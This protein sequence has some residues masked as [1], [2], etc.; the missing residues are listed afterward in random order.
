[1]NP[2]KILIVDDDPDFAEGVAISLEIAGHGVEIAASGEEAIVKFRT[3]NF[4]ITFMDV[5]MPGMNGVE[6]FFE[7]RRI[8][9]QARVVMMTAHRVEHLLRRAIDG[10]VQGVM[11]K[12]F[13][14][15]ELLRMLEQ[16]KPAGIILLADDDRDFA[17]CLETV[18]GEAGYTTT[19]ARTGREA[20]DTIVDDGFDVLVLDLRLPVLSGLEV[21]LELR[22]RGREVPT[23]VITG[24][25]V[26]EAE[27]LTALR[28]M[29]VAGCLMKPFNSADLLQA[30]DVIMSK[31][32]VEDA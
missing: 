23:I 8:K 32:A 1:M 7:F 25:H 16:V 20:V 3:S 12:P 27:T 17:E 4:D 24:Y 30:I 31:P 5:R 6:S 18:L 29:S 2:L 19:V 22:K 14:S 11:Q 28:A 9:P 21:Y 26:E 10:G 13:G 15:D